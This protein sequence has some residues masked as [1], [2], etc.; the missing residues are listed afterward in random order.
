MKLKREDKEIDVYYSDSPTE[1]ENNVNWI[2]LATITL[3]L[4]NPFNLG[5]AC[6]NNT[7]VARAQ[8][9][10]D[11]I[12]KNSSASLK[13]IPGDDNSPAWNALSYNSKYFPGVGESLQRDYEL[14]QGYYVP[15]NIIELVLEFDTTIGEANT[16]LAELDADILLSMPGRSDVPEIG[17][18][19]LLLRLNSSTSFEMLEQIVKYLENNPNVHSVRPIHIQTKGNSLPSPTEKL[20]WSSHSNSSD[21]ST[22]FQT[23]KQRWLVI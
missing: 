13:Q 8:F 5:L 17:G 16:I 9:D 7:D 22:F 4:L 14:L 2:L 23:S 1:M 10:K 6:G 21:I 18:L 3:T 12:Q 19:L 15:K 11:E 20:I